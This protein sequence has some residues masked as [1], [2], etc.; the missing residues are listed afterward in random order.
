[1][2]NKIKQNCR[3]LLFFTLFV[4]VFPFSISYSSEKNNDST[5]VN[6]I[7]NE[8][9]ELAPTDFEK[10]KTLSNSAINISRKI[11]W[12]KGEVNSLNLLGEAYR[13]K[14]LIQ[15]SIENHLKALELSEKN[16]YSYGIAESHS[17]LGVS[18]FH[19]SDFP[20]AYKNF[21]ISYKQFEKLNDKRGIR[22]CLNFL[23]ILKTTIGNY[24]DGIAYFN[25]ALEISESLNDKLGIA[26]QLGNIGRVNFEIKNYKKAIEY[27]NNAID[28]FSEINDDFNKSIFTANSGLAYLKLKDYNH[29][30]FNFK[31]ALNYSEKLSNAFRIAH[32]NKNIGDLKYAMALDEDLQNTNLTKKNLLKESIDFTTKALNIFDNLEIK[33][34]IQNC[35]LSLSKSYEEI[36]DYTN[37]LVYF[38]Q[39]RSLQDSIYSIENKKAIAKLEIAQQLKIKDKEIEILSQAKEYQNFVKWTVIS[40]TIL[41]FFI[42][43]L[44]IYM[45]IRKKRQN[46]ELE[47]NIRIRKETESLLLKNEKEL[48]KHKNKLEELIAIRTENLENEIKERKRTEEDLLIAVERSETSSKAKST[49]LANMSHELRTPLFG[50]LGYSEIL[51]KEINDLEKRSMAEGIYRT[52]SRLLNTLSMILDFARVESDRYEVICRE[53]DVMPEIN[54]IFN[55]F[56]GTAAIK[57]LEYELR[58]Q[59]DSEILNTDIT[60][61]R[62]IVENLINNAIKFTE[63]GSVIVETESLDNNEFILRVRD[64]GIGI[65]KKNIPLIFK[66]FRQISEG[67]NKAYPGTGLGLSITKRYVKILNGEINVKTALGFGSTFEIKFTKNQIIVKQSA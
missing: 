44:F 7:Y 29:A 2:D 22:N 12:I 21:D 4:F 65:N 10:C 3:F 13:F 45:F 20:N 56:K 62:V 57:G 43:V 60:L 52:G 58:S 48:N 61:I 30:Y 17:K 42:S 26:T 46:F 33:E 50:I 34:E 9:W 5:Y 23:G 66:E 11:G 41:F 54:A 37:A 39:A 64:T 35:K 49:F 38:K 53:V 55:S 1:M 31:S 47:K 16:N 59:K 18:Y 14:G 32:Q 15:E 63:K 8:A 36:G 51:S 25:K 27:Y 40:I 28:V 24:D 67:T 19:I 6:S